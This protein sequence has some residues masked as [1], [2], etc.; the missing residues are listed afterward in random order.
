M[1]EEVKIKSII[2]NVSDDT[3][4]AG[5]IAR[6][7]LGTEWRLEIHHEIRGSH[8]HDFILRRCDV[9]QVMS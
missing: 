7:L 8:D 1:D 9:I 5:T 4:A 6:F 2:L 3:Y